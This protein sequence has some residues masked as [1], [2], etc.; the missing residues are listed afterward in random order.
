MGFPLTDVLTDAAL[1][2]EFICKIC[3]CLAGP[4]HE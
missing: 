1:V 4:S 3:H 2:E